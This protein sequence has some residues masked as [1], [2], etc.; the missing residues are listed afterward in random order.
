MA[1]FVGAVIGLSYL[2]IKGKDKG[3][4]IPFGPYLAIAGWLTLIYGSDIA[5]MYIQWAL[6]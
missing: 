1:S 4:H 2:A 5:D 6:A 3:S